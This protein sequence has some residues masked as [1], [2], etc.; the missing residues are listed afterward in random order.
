MFPS[1]KVKYAL[2]RIAV[3]YFWI[4]A[5]EL[6]YKPR[7]DIGF[8]SE[9]QKKTILLH[10]RGEQRRFFYECKL[11]NC[12]SI[13]QRFTAAWTVWVNKSTSDLTPV[14]LL[15]CIQVGFS[16]TRENAFLPSLFHNLILFGL[17]LP[18]S[19]DSTII[20]LTS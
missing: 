15:Y 7:A 14:T 1:Y 20:W 9:N 12:Y 13:E 8:S 6:L 19:Y 5:W 16:T 3:P 4:R 17:V 10:T 18:P 2:L 11:L